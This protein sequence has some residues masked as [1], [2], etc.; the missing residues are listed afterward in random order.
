MNN[1]M[2]VPGFSVNPP[3]LILAATLSS[4]YYVTGG[5]RERKKAKFFIIALVTL[6]IAECSPLHMLAMHF[7][8]GA[9]MIVHVLLLLVCGPLFVLSIPETSPVMAEKWIHRC[10]VLLSRHTFLC[11]FM[12]VGMMWVWHI[13]AIFDAS[14]RDASGMGGLYS[15]IQPMS[16]LLAGMLFS[17]PLIGPE[18]ALHIHPLTGIIYLAS[19]CASCSLL[20]LLITFAPV[21]T[22][23]YYLDMKAG[24]GP[25]HLDPVADQQT[26]G[27]VMWVP[28]CFV[29]LTGCIGLLM[30][31]FAAGN[32]KVISGVHSLNQAHASGE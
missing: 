4:L 27:L 15:L 30:R 19:A 9:H 22:Y 12:G 32:R 18:T 24:S 10:S 21:G 5:F 17:W 7:Y 11:W 14:M 6:L 1:A 20:G 16:F 23:H 29:Y 13:P 3:A 2:T 8:F 31:W 28:C 25:W 26:A